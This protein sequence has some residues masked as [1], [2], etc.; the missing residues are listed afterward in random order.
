[1]TGPDVEAPDRYV[2]YPGTE[3]FISHLHT[4]HWDMVT[5]AY[6]ITPVPRQIKMHEF[7]YKAVNEVIYDKDGIVVRTIPAIHIGDGPVSFIIEYAGMKLAFAGDTTPNK[8][9]LRFGRASGRPM[10]GRSR[11]PRI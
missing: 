9:F 3:V 11:S 8:C 2:Y 5:R 6:K 10:T 7:D 1:M 4:D